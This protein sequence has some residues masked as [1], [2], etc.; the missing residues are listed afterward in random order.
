MYLFYSTKLDIAFAVEQL[1]KQNTN[2]KIGNLRVTKRV[3]WYFKGT[4]Q[5][6]IVYKASNINPAPYGLIEYVNSNYAGDPEDKKSVIG[7]CF[8]INRA[9]L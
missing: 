6:K 4:I 7:Y 5:L 3:I 9:V 2:L 1:S 8:F